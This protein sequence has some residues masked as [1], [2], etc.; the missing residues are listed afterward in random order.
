M[1][2][3]SQG[4]AWVFFV[5]LVAMLGDTGAYMVGTLWGRHKLVPRISPGK[6]IE[7]SGGGLIANLLGA[8]VGWIWVVPQRG[9]G[10]L[11]CLAA[12]VGLLA[13]VGD[14]VESA[15]KRAAGTKDSGTVLPGHGGILDRMDSLLFPI[16]FIYYYTRII[17]G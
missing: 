9:L 1:V 14:L 7:G 6:T 15:L 17:H 8:V 2:R 13:Q 3:G 5:F 4:A 16:A 11:A 12:V 10:E